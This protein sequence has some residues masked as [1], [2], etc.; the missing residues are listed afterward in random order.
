MY[1]KHPGEIRHSG[2]LFVLFIT[3]LWLF[4]YYI[5]SKRSIYSSRRL[6]LVFYKSTRILRTLSNSAFKYRNQ[7]IMAILYAHLA[8]GVFMFTMDLHNPFSLSKEVAKFIKENQIEDKLVVGD[9]DYVNYIGPP[10]SG[11]LDQKIYYVGGQRSGW[12]SF[13]IWD[14]KRGYTNRQQV[15]NFFKEIDRV[16]KA[17]NTNLF[18]VLNY[19][20]GS[21]QAGE[22]NQVM[23]RGDIKFKNYCFKFPNLC[24]SEMSKFTEGIVPDEGKVYYLYHI[25]NKQNC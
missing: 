16:T 12:G 21:C 23:P 3:C 19:Q 13:T 22:V 6:S 10:L 1:I 17:R 24:I 5:K 18:L 14:D 9:L 11:Y 15:E 25:Q 2:Y 20:L 7:L 8:A 4:N